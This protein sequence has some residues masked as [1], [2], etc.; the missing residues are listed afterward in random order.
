[1]EKLEVALP[2]LGSLGSKPWPLPLGVSLR[3]ALE[4]LALDLHEPCADARHLDRAE[5]VL[6]QA[7]AAVRQE[8]T[9]PAF[10]IRI[11]KVDLLLAHA[12]DVGLWR[13][14]EAQNVPE[15]PPHVGV[16]EDR[17]RGAGRQKL[18]HEL[19]ACSR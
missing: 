8:P 17:I 14:Q 5:V 9:A 16:D 4:H 11:R 1:S 6:M 19:I 12:A 15:R 10:R 3:Q 7:V 2:N 18:G 13:C